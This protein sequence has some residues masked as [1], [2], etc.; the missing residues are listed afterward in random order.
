MT[1][2]KQMLGLVISSLL[3]TTTGIGVNNYLTSKT[4]MEQAVLTFQQ[5]EMQSR[6]LL[7]Q[8]MAEGA[9][10]AI[11]AALDA[12]AS[13]ELALESYSKTFGSLNYAEGG[14]FF[15]LDSDGVFIHHPQKEFV[16]KDM[17][18]W[19]DANGNYVT[20]LL[21]AASKKDG[22]TSYWWPK[23]SGGE[24]YEKISYAKAISG[25]DWVVGTGLYVNDIEDSVSKMEISAEKS[26]NNE[27]MNQILFSVIILFGLSFVANFLIN[28][29]TRPLDDVRVKITELSK[30][31]G[32]LTIRL[33]ENQGGDEIQALCSSFNTFMEYLNGVIRGI[34]EASGSVASISGELSVLSEKLNEEL[35]AHHAQTESV[36]ASITEMSASSEQVAG[37]ARNVSF[38][39]DEATEKSRTAMEAVK[40]SDVV[41]EELMGGMKLS[42]GHIS[43]LSE[44]SKQIHIM[45]ESIN[46]IAEQTNLLA[47]NAAIE[48]ARAGEQGRGFAVVADEVRALAGRSSDATDDIAKLLSVLDNLV[49]TA[50]DSMSGS[51]DKTQETVEISSV[52]GSEL[53]SISQQ[54]ENISMMTSEI[55]TASTQ[56]SQAVLEVNE[57]INNTQEV[58]REIKNVSDDTIQIVSRLKESGNRLES[59]VSGFKVS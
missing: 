29:T 18:S 17:S 35:N 13:D 5:K 34:S 20:K 54:I 1:F 22:W 8:S 27:I 59:V 31:E 52:I 7:I 26:L 56:Q 3:L 11:E 39:T 19:K 40:N 47:L 41:V 23:V 12:G 49:K 15:I 14:Y 30:G 21:N 9:K 45:L 50:L 55:A 24:P 37:S 33:D 53:G 38:S 42:A 46:S 43:E 2:K 4:S 10:Q 25:T 28:K 32:D 51:E 48:A 44:H 57:S 58:V 16:G 6:E 36:S